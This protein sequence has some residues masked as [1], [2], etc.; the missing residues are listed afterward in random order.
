[1]NALIVEIVLML[2]RH[3]LTAVGLERLLN[4][5]DFNVKV[6]AGVAALVGIAMSAAR[7]IKRQSVDVKV[8]PIPPVPEK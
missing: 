5:S 6:A 1:M 2:V 7:K 4:D 3:G 8:T